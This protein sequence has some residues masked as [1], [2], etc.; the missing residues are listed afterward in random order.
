[1]SNWSNVD[2]M[3]VPKDVRIQLESIAPPQ[4]LANIGVIRAS[5][6][7]PAQKN[8]N[9]R[10]E[11]EI[12][13]FSPV[14]R[15]V[16]AQVRIADTSITLTGLCAAGGRSLLTSEIALPLEGWHGASVKL[17]G[18]DDALEADNTHPFVVRVRP[19]PSFALLTREPAGPAALSSYFTSRALDS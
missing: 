19:L 17:I 4:P 8:R 2:F 1:K 7:G 18:I 14:A 9:A 10:L 15:N 3:S 16:Q 11:L 6:H 12:G 13:N 5:V